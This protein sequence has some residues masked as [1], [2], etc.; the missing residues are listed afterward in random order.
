[1]ASMMLP[2]GRGTSRT[3]RIL[4]THGVP[5]AYGGAETAAEMSFERLAEGMVTVDLDWTKRNQPLFRGFR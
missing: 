4:G 1:M 5:A 3:V 2:A